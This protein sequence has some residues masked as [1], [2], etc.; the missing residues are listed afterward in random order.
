MK[1]QVIN[2]FG[3]TSVMNT[4]EMPKPAI[5]AGYVLVKVHATSVNPIDFK[6]RSGT[7][8]QLAPDFPAVLHG[9]FAGVI[10]EVGAGVDDFKIGEEV[11][12]CAGGVK[13]EGGALAEYMLAD[14]HLIAK[15]PTSLTMLEAAALPL[16]SITAWES[17]FE[18]VTLS[19]GQKVLIHA[20]TGGVGHVAI[21]LAKWAGAQVY[22][23]V[24]SA[25]KAEL[26]KSLGAIEAINYRSESVQEYVDRLTQGKGFDVIL[27]TIG[28]DNIDKSLMAVALYGNIITI[29][30]HSSHDL[31]PLFSKSA[32]LHVVFMLLPMLC[33][34]QRKRHGEILNKIA[35]IADK[36]MLK[37]LI[38]PRRFSFA[39]AGQ[40]HALLESGKAIGKVVI[41]IQN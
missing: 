5:K 21:Q 2:Q 7:F 13:G 4:V 12:G 16:V 17:L 29:L 41:D 27:D 3:N 18:K 28:G 24:S 9:D 33:H 35:A 39:E 26:A 8:P 37:P 31:S 40:A 20:G 11:F 19:P 22:T 14:A 32:S 10:E 6:L 38:D 1:A 15:K 34:Q 25:E 36:G 30:S 23:T